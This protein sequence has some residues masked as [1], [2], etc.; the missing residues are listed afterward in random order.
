MIPD[1]LIVS[2]NGYGK[3]TNLI[4]YPSQKRGGKG[5]A[6]IKESDRNG[7]VI[8]SILVSDSD[9]L[10]L[11]SSN[12]NVTR[13]KASDI[14]RSGRNTKGVKIM[15]LKKGEKLVDI[16]KVVLEQ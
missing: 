14:R 11:I 9:E 13:I 5:I 7:K 2:E 12:N 16:G 15:K 1:L 3:K 6:A 8:A 10:M 4:K